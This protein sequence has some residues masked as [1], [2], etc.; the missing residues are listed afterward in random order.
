MITK[1]RTGQLNYDFHII[2]Y[3]I[4]I[5]IENEVTS[6]SMAIAESKHK[7]YVT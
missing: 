1:L 6:F 7:T 4:A 5:A 3:M 2:S